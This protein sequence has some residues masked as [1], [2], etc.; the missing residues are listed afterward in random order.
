MTTCL[1]RRQ[2]GPWQPLAHP[3]SRLRVLGIVA[4]V[5][6]DLRSVSFLTPE[7][8]DEALPCLL[9]LLW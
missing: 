1:L 4:D 2:R 7:L 8:L 9:S 3:D 5:H 6:V